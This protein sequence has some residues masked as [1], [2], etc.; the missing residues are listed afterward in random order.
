MRLEDV[1]HI[2]RR[3]NRTSPDFC[4]TVIIKR[5]HSMDL[6]DEPTAVMVKFIP[7]KPRELTRQEKKQIQYLHDY[8]KLYYQMNAQGELEWF[9]L[10]QTKKCGKQKTTK[11]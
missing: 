6:L 10:R 8:H 3:L 5:D 4:E 9:N 2:Y 7:K 11:T 1:F